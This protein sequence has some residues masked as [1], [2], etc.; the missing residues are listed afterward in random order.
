MKKST[1]IV[2][3]ICIFILSGCTKTE[4]SVKDQYNSYY[5]D[6]KILS[7]TTKIDIRKDEE[8]YANIKG[9]FHLI[10]DPLTLYKDDTEIG[11][12]DDSFHFINQDSHGIYIDNVFTCDM[13]GHFN[14]FG[15]TYTIYD[16]E[17]KEIAHVT[18]NTLNTSGTISDSDDNIIAEY[19][20][21]ITNRDYSVKIYKNEIFTDDEI[22]LM[23][24][25]FYSDR[26]ADAQ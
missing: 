22:L 23:C 4:T 15:D 19:T 6:V 8:S 25:A 21:G 12:A 11:K 18:F 24:A 14:V 20:S 5:N 2:I 9:D 10:E 7:L 3:L 13:V 26:T 16:A 17:E 1:T